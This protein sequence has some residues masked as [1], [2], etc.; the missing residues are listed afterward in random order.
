MAGD[1]IIQVAPTMAVAE[2]PEGVPMV[3]AS[4]ADT[5]AALAA[6]GV[7]V[8]PSAPADGVATDVSVMAS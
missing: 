4:Y 8:G 6:E 7:Q 3:V 5:A 2:P 1:P